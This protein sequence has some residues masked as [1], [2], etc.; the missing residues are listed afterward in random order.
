ML[1]NLQWLLN[2]L[3]S[4]VEHSRSLAYSFLK[5]KDLLK[6]PYVT[7][8]HDGL[9][10]FEAGLRKY[11]PFTLIIGALLVLYLLCY[12]LGLLAKFWNSISKYSQLII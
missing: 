3:L 6:K 4:S 8:A 9:I 5:E 2:K 11:S 7:A 12:I 1:D 10:G